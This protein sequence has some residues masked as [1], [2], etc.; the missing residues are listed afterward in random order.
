[1]SVH[2]SADTLDRTLDSIL[3][4]DF[5]DL[6]FIVIDDGS[7]DGGGELLDRRARA[8]PRLV[9]VHQQ[10]TGLT[11]A[12]QR[13]CGHARGT[14]IARQDAGGDI[15]M[16]SRLQLQVKQLQACPEA[17]MVSCAT[18]SVGP[19]DE[20]LF[21]IAMTEAELRDGLHT[22]RLP[23]LRGPSHHGNTMFRRDA[24]ELVGGYRPAFVVAQ[25]MDLWLRMIEVG[26]C[27]SMPEVLYQAKHTL[28]SI[29]SRHGDRQR[30]FGLAAMECA[31]Q[32][33]AGKPEPDW[34]VPLITKSAG[35]T[36]SLRAESAAFH[37]FIASCLRSH[38]PAA[39]RV[40]LLRGLRSKPTLAPAW[41]RLIQ[42]W[43]RR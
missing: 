22:L 42:L 21:N 7:T 29:S 14:Y 32:R 12:L 16:K 2:N 43:W 30:Q 8:D 38:D 9:V 27:L 4:Q 39:A 3:D 18:R 6:E 11:V 33:R 17:V 41:W 28:G 23:G 40:H 24:Y 15:S 25:D 19:D 37:Y 26:R 20:F 5:M 10:N 36:R 31:R 34:E 1:M 13:G 35:K